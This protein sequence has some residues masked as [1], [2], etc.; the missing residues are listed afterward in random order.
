MRST[1]WRMAAATAAVVV[2]AWGAG[3]RAVAAPINPAAFK[4]RYDDAKRTADVAAQVRVLAAVCTDTEGAPGEPPMV[5]L[6]VSLQVLEADKGPLKKNE[7][8]TVSHKVQLP[9]G[10]GP[11]AY[12]YMAAMRQ[13]PF[14]PGVK[15]FAALRWD[16]EHRCYSVAGGW[17]PEPNGAPIP[18]EVG[19]A[20]TAGDGAKSE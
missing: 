19:K 3:P 2:L 1:M 9:A 11:R 17:V 4:D 5:T 15:G 6:Q 16:K 8:V 7:V 12:G 10:P 14:N 18:T 20:F 13:F